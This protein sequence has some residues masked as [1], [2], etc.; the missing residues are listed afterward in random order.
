MNPTNVS[1]QSPAVLVGATTYSVTTVPST[2][3]RLS[4]PTGS[5]PCGGCRRRTP[6]VARSRGRRGS[7]GRGCCGPATTRSRGRRRGAARPA[8][9]GRS[10]TSCVSRELDHRPRRR[11]DAVGIRSTRRPSGRL[12]NTLFM[13]DAPSQFTDR[14]QCVGITLTAQEAPRTIAYRHCTHCRRNTKPR[15]SAPAAGTTAFSR[16]R[17]APMPPPSPAPGTPARC[18]PRGCPPRTR[19]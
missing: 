9:S 17:P 10:R 11:L 13:T 6:R 19:G 16:K 1:P 12:A 14:C 8:R 15:R 4:S 2:G 18:P 5:H 7:P 3:S